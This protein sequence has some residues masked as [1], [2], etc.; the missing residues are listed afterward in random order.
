MDE[1][2][3]IHEAPADS[4]DP[5]A[6][7]QGYLLAGESD[8]QV[9][10]RLGIN[11]EVIRLYHNVFFHVRD[12]LET[13]DLLWHF[14]GTDHT[15]HEDET[16]KWMRILGL[17]GGPY[18]L[19][20]YEEYRRHPPPTVPQNREGISDDALRTLRDRLYMRTMLITMF[21]AVEVKDQLRWRMALELVDIRKYGEW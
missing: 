12:R 9:S 11:S 8:K 3:A 5:R 15:V 13:A 17:I 20:A 14:V 19:E 2:R 18:F 6:R 7:L 10:K 21:P 16:D 1:A 4:K